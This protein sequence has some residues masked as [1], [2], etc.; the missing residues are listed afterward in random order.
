MLFVTR[1]AYITASTSPTSHPYDKRSVLYR[2]QSFEA[3]EPMSPGGDGPIGRRV[4]RAEAKKVRGVA[5]V[6]VPESSDVPKSKPFRAE[7]RYF[8]VKLQAHVLCHL[9]EISLSM[10]TSVPRGRNDAPARGASTK[11]QVKISTFC[12]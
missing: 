2:L 3:N 7:K 6:S 11:S 10:G 5:H 12:G 8:T 1:A 9:P 4:D